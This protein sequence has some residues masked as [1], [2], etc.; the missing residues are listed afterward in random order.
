VDYNRRRRRRR[1]KRR[2][3]K[4]HNPGIWVVKAGKIRSLMSV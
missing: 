4:S 3:E 2:R 1:R